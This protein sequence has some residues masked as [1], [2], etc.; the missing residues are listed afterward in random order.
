MGVVD[1]KAF[2]FVTVGSSS[3]LKLISLACFVM[4][5]VLFISFLS[6]VYVSVG[7][8]SSF[9]IGALYVETSFGSKLG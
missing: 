5:E 2:Y 6:P 4:K 3:S 9:K 7:N 1:R 8:W